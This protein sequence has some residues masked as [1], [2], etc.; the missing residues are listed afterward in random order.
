[1]ASNFRHSGSSL[2]PHPPLH[3]YYQTEEQREQLLATQFDRVAHDYNWITQASSFGSGKWYRREALKRSGLTEGNT[4][5]DVACGPGTVSGCAQYIV[6]ETGRVIGLDPSLGMVTEA[7]KQGVSTVLQGKAE[8]LPF[9]DSIFDFISMGYALRHVTDLT[10]TFKEYLR[11]LKPGGRLLILEISRPDSFLPYHMSR[12]FLKHI[13]PWMSYL[14]TKNPH[15]HKL[16]K[17]Y[18]DTIES[19]VPPE[20]ILQALKNSGFI[21]SQQYTLFGGLLRDYSGCKP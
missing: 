1:M 21:Q 9:P 8:H 17:Y 3:D 16:M 12:V 14:G 7:Q 13:V 10:L 6:G 2:A 11:V 4:I 19:C 15:A 5:L 18:W 20:T